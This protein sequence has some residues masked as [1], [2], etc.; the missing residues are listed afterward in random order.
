MWKRILAASAVCGWLV[1][2]VAAA[3]PPARMGEARPGALPTDADLRVK[4]AIQSSF[5]ALPIQNGVILVPLSRRPG[6]DNIELREGTVAVNGTVVTG[7]ELRQRLGR[8][9]DPILELSYMDAS[10]Q[11]R[12]LLPA[13][14]GTPAGVEPPGPP[15]PGAAAEQPAR[16]PEAEARPSEPRDDRAF[17]RRSSGRV[18]LG[19]SITVAEDESVNGAV[20]AIGGD[21]D[22][23]G[24]VREAVVAIGGNVRLGPR[25]EVQGDVTTVGG[26]ITRDPE[27]VVHGQVN[28]VEFPAFHI[29]PVGPWS[30]R[31]DPW[32]GS[33]PWRTVRLV[34]TLVRMGLFALLAAL[35]LLLAP[36]AVERIDRTVRDEPFKAAL[37]GFF[38]QLIFVPLLVITV[39][40]LVISI[41]GIPLL[42]LVPFAVLAFFVALLLGFTGSASAVAHAARDRFAWSRPAPFAL[43]VVGLLLIWGVTMVGRV[44]A[45]P[46]GPFAWMAGLV[47]LVGFLVEYAAWTVG[48]GGALLT[49][50]GRAGR[51]YP[52][53]LPPIPPDV[54]PVVGPD[55]I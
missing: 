43:L 10:A 22:I 49:R 48:L 28:E 15:P 42:V 7:A 45:L 53:P 12:L 44:L 23:N 46:G 16:P 50:F 54:P 24:R 29:R 6:V 37:V 14:A 51:L 31:F 5:R 52:Q 26:S 38:A 8:D 11:R 18:R 36:R 9:A 34:G 1:S 30:V 21:A 35:I 40:V 33:A 47:L 4:Q 3:Q 17:R 41:I 32:W 20:V 55:E 25:A 39:L 27:A 2:A 13:E 19:G